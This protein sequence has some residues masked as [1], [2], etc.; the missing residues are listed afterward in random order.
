MTT[1]IL[2][3]GHINNIDQNDPENI[4]I[5]IEISFGFKGLTPPSDL[6]AIVSISFP[7]F[8]LSNIISLLYPIKYNFPTLPHKI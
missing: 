8:T 5:M 7:Y 3:C 6:P 4:I 2:I 1:V